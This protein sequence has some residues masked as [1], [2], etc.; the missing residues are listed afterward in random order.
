MAKIY[1]PPIKCQ[2]IKTKLVEWIKDVV[3][4]SGDGRWIEPFVGSGVVGFNLLPKK[5]VFSDINPH[6]IEFYNAIQRE[7]ITPAVARQFLEAE[8]VKLAQS[9]A[10]YYYEVRERFNNSHAPLDF[11]FLNRS[12]FNGVIRFNQKGGFNVPFGHK[13]QRFAP[14]YITKIVNQIAF[15]ADCVKTYDWK[16]VHQD[17]GLALASATPQDHIY[18]DPPYI[19]RHVDYFNSWDEEQE[20][21]LYQKL[22]NSP[23]HFVLS[24]WHSNQH[25]QNHYIDSL[26]AQFYIVTRE[27]FYHVGAAESNRK[28]MLEALVLN[29]R[30]TAAS[31]QNRQNG[32]QLRLLEPRVKYQVNANG[33]K[34]SE[35][36]T[37]ESLSH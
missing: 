28:P 18:C 31:P 16:F 15:V 14:A 11:L 25:R 32:Y 30:P 5:A 33:H 35:E 37:L 6:L 24:T 10:D 17:F 13:P 19:G 21:R 20:M 4:W 2:G 22:K 27:H 34:K 29:Y 36:S 26:W 12:C 1:V 7:N 8:G 9:G 23:A 3:D